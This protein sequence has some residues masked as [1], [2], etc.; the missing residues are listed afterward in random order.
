M[1][2]FECTLPYTKVSACCVNISCKHFVSIRGP[3]YRPIEETTRLIVHL[4]WRGP[5]VVVRLDERMCAPRKNT[6]LDREAE[7]EK[8]EEKSSKVPKKKMPAVVGLDVLSRAEPSPLTSS[9]VAAHVGSSQSR[10]VFFVMR[11][12][13]AHRLTYCSCPSR[14]SLRVGKKFAV[15]QIL[16]PVIDVLLLLFS[17]QLC[18][19]QGTV[20]HQ[21]E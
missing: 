14:V 7:K 15:T 8:H 20:I 5:R 16:E 19:F 18:S 10:G 2:E 1:I 12:A 17:L 21:L 4:R 11:T 9:S 6:S 13:A 3:L